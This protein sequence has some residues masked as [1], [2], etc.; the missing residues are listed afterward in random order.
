MANAILGVPNTIA[1]VAVGSG[2]AD[3][4]ANN[5]LNDEP[6]LIFRSGSIENAAYGHLD[7]NVTNPNVGGILLLGA[8]TTSGWS[9]NVEVRNV[10][11]N[12]APITSV[13]LVGSTNRTADTKKMWGIFGTPTTGTWYRVI[14]TNNTGAAAK[15]E[16]WRIIFFKKIQPADNIEEGP[17]I[18]VDDRS[19]RRYTRS[20]RRV[21]DPTVI[22]PAFQG[23]WPWLTANEVK[24]DFVPLVYKRAG[25]YPVAFILDPDDTAWGED[26]I[27]YGDLEKS[28]SIDRHNNDNNVFKFSIVS[29]AP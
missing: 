26:Y 22:C 1:S 24:Q 9:V 2:G 11:D 25:S 6:G 5:L 13:S 18:T 8:P 27:W 7:I 19:E 16:A 14:F 4:T 29:I 12:A 17:S 21:I 20:G 3:I 23:Q 15:F 28:L 10:N